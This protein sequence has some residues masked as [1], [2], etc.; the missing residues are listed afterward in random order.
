MRK[1]KKL[2]IEEL[3]EAAGNKVWFLPRAMGKTL[4]NKILAEMIAY[5]E[6][7]KDLGIDLVLYAKVLQNGVYVKGKEPEWGGVGTKKDI[8]HYCTVRF[9]TWH[10]VLNYG[11]TEDYQSH[12]IS[13][14]LESYG[15]LWALTREE[16]L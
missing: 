11:G 8:Q 16:L 2:T 6:T 7:E 15:T 10:L 9:N 1:T 4:A 14:P 12:I 5:K 3:R 13:D